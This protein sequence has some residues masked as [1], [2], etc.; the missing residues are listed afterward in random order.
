ML[1][2]KSELHDK[3]TRTMNTIVWKAFPAQLDTTQDKLYDKPSITCKKDVGMELCTFVIMLSLHL[4]SVLIF[5]TSIPTSFYNFFFILVMTI[6]CIADLNGLFC[7][8]S[9]GRHRSRSCPSSIWK[10]INQ[11]TTSAK[12]HIFQ[13]FASSYFHTSDQA[14][15]KH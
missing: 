3:I 12:D 10:S 2:H 9:F 7:K 5:G 4:V 14:H 13:N 11:S 6:M 1:Y 15:E 8:H